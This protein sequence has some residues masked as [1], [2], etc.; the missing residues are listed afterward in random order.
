MCMSSLSV[1]EA[2]GRRGDR[3]HCLHPLHRVCPSASSPSKVELKAVQ[4]QLS[5]NGQAPDD[6]RFHS[7]V[8]ALAVPVYDTGV[9]SASILQRVRRL[10]LEGVEIS[11]LPHLGGPISFN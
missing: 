8:T 10:L 7:V 5:N 9:A 1:A 2:S 4:T 6:V 11:R 3:R